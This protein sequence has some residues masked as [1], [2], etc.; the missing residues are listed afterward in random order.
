MKKNLF[1]LFAILFVA[2]TVTACSS[3]DKDENLVEIDSEIV[4]EWSLFKSTKDKYPV[5]LKAQPKEGVTDDEYSLVVPGFIEEPY[6]F[7][8]AMSMGA[9]MGSHKLAPML[10]AIEFRKNG[11]IVAKYLDINSDGKPV[12][13]VK[14][15]PEGLMKYSVNEK[16]SVIIVTPNAAN[17]IEKMKSDGT[18]NDMIYG[19]IN[20]YLKGSFQLSYNLS[21]NNSAVAITVDLLDFSKANIYKIAE[22]VSKAEIEEPLKQVAISIVEQM[23]KILD[24]TDVLEAGLNLV[25]NNK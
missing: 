22:L 18:G 1:Y 5:I 15:S 4:G 24:L 23:P 3:S 14:T 13:E 19:L 25:K 10:E 7:S 9:M 20:Q 12:G 21:D 6:L 11:E 2:S 8:N 16:K 17:I